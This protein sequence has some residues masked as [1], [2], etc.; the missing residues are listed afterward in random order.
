[1]SEA[2]K[3][4]DIS[5][6]QNF[7]DFKKVRAA[8]VI[9]MIHKATEGTGY[10]DPNRAQNCANAIAAGIKVCCYHWIKPKQDPVA[11]MNYFLKVVNPQP[12]ER[13]VI[14][15]EEDGCTLADLKTAVQRLLDDPRKLKVTI[16]SG[17]L[18]KQQLG[19]KRDALLAENTDLWLA[20]YTAGT[21]TWPTATYPKWAL[22]QYSETGKIDGISGSAVDLDRFN[23]TDEELLA[24]ISPAYVA[25]PQPQ[26]EPEP[27]NIPVIVALTVP[28]GVDITVTINGDKVHQD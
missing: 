16:Y 21:P 10:S 12:G 26:P 13:M 8:G 25:P 1:M 5:H 20:Q 28:D 11:Q 24:W 3:C 9:A 7:P 27:E 6:W 15:Y 14:D 2:V 4:I 22:W 19:T 18:L 23:G 17:H